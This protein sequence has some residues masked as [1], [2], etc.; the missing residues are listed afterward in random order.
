MRFR[1][2]TG[3]WGGNYEAQSSQDAIRLFFADIKAGRIKLCQLGLLGEWSAAKRTP[4]QFRIAPALFKAGLLSGDGLVASFR[5]AGLE[6][7]PVEIMSMVTADAWMVGLSA[8][9]E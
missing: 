6:F 8:E 1:I 7:E 9:V 3:D 2:V 4:I 5:S